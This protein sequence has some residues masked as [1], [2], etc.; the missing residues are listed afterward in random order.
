MH[1]K[2][3]TLFRGL[4][5]KPKGWRP[6]ERYMHIWEDNIRMYLEGT[7]WEGMDWISLAKDKDQQQ[8]SVNTV[9]NCQVP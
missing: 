6:P 9:I 2:M 8:A 4:V 7:G 3:R 1:G 5:E